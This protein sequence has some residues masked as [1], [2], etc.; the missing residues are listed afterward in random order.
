[1]QSVYVIHAFLHVSILSRPR[2]WPV[3]AR[4][5]AIPA[6]SITDAGS[7]D[8]GTRLLVF[9]PLCSLRISPFV[10]HFTAAIRR[11]TRRCTAPQIVL[12]GDWS[13]GAESWVSSL[14]RTGWGIHTASQAASSGV[15]STPRVDPTLSRTI[16]TASSRAVWRPTA[17][18][19]VPWTSSR[20]VRG[21]AKARRLTSPDKTDAVILHER[22]KRIVASPVVMQSKST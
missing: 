15:V 5:N 20:W 18:S 21:P 12:T 9:H 6:G 1:M 3:A 19:V 8:A 16:F 4:S 7:L 14:A 10:F 13:P 11:A 2:D 17:P 22:A